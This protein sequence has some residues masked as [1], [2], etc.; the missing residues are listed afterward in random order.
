MDGQP[1]P[2]RVQ[3][4]RNQ[5]GRHFEGKR[6]HDVVGALETLVSDTCIAAG[7]QDEARALSAADA[8]AAD[9]R[10]II[11]ERFAVQGKGH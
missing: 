4:L 10:N 3:I 8:I 9:I 2:K 6:I 1:D 5:C 7:M 11:R